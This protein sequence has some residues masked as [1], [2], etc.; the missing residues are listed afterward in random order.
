M[1]T[2]P[3]PSNKERL[4]KAEETLVLLIRTYLQRV[5]SKLTATEFVEMAKATVALLDQDPSGPS[6]SVPERKQLLDTAL[7]T[8]GTQ[9]SQPI[10]ALGEQIPKR[11]AKPL[12]RLVRYQ[13]I[14]RT[15]GLDATLMTLATQTLENIA[16]PLTP[17]T[18]RTTLE[19]SKI[20]IPPEL[21]TQDSLDDLAKALCFKLQ[22]RT[23]S[24]N[25]TKSDQEIAAQ[26]NQ[27]IVEFKI[28]YQPLTDVTQPKWDSDLSVSS[29]FF[30]PSNFETAGND[31]TWIPPHIED[32]SSKDETNA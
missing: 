28:K 17:E 22:L 4:T 12:A 24:P 7:Q 31:F 8:F 32:K 15:E 16:Q 18:L 6:L 25:A 9:L 5:S 19:N 26:L 29:P 2:A 30:T 14:I 27:T 10:P 20:T 21:T 1:A 3:V 13:K 23:P 11:I